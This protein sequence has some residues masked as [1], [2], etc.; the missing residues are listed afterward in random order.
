MFLSAAQAA[1]LDAVCSQIIPTDETAGAHEAHCVRFID[2][3]LTRF[4]R[5][6]QPLYRDGLAQLRAQAL[7]QFGEKQGFA[8]LSAEQQVQLLRR[9]E[10]TPFFM[11]ARSHTIIAML[12]SPGHGGNAQKCGWKLI[13]FDDALRFAAPFGY[14]DGP[15]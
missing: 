8:A 3:A 13:E 11:A 15:A 14:Y 6:S 2:R 10:H 4:L 7:A 1:D 5:L 9:I 12:A